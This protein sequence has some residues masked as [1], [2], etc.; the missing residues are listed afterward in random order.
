MKKVGLI[1]FV[2]ALF[3]GVVLS[4][5]FSFGRISD[6]LFNFSINLCGT[7]GSGHIVTESRDVSDFSG[8]D[9]GGIY[10]VDVTAQ[11]DFA[12][13]IEADDNLLPLI[14]TEVDGD[15][16]KIESDSKISPTSQIL[17]HIFAPDITSLEVSGAAAVD[18]KDLDNSSLS[19]DSSGASKINVAGK[20][21]KLTVDISGA[22]RVDA[23]ALEAEDATVDASG[24]SHVNVNVSG[25]LRTDASGASKIVYSGTPANI[26]KK[27]SGASS[28]SHK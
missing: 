5:I 26:E 3:V 10:K 18:V 6:K 21:D 1:I 14:R 20:T 17:V 12:V 15:V 11:K 4:N 13:K 8:I 16:L 23:E 19:V 24:A 9:V 25:S 27:T 2:V 22:T 7:K 28:V